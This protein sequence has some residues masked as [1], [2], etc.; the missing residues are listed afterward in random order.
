MAQSKGTSIFT[1]KQAKANTPYN[2]DNLTP[3]NAKCWFQVLQVGSPQTFLPTIR[4]L[5]Y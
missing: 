5:N 3:P 1:C 4:L 2:E